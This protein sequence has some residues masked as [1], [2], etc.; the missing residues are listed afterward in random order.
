MTT[1]QAIGILAIFAV[2]V[3]LMM[4]RKLPTILALP[5]MAVGIA[6]VAGIPFVSGDPEQ[7]T[8]AKDVLESG[9]MRMSTAIAG[10]DLRRMVRQDPD[11]S[12]R[13]ENDYPQ[14]G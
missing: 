11:Q 14:G 2:C 6:L 3:V 7:F 5:I 9:A 10:A 12:R 1:L 4:T 13:H 8:I